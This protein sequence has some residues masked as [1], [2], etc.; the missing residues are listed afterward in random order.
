MSKPTSK[1]K[2]AI[3][4]IFVSLLFAFFSIVLAFSSLFVNMDRLV[5][6]FTTRPLDIV[7]LSI[8]G[9]LLYILGYTMVATGKKGYA[10]FKNFMIVMTVIFFT[11]VICLAV[12]MYFGPYAYPFAIAGLFIETMVRRYIRKLFW[13]YSSCFSTDVLAVLTT[14]YS[15]LYSPAYFRE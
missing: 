11:L 2:T 13:E 9:M 5:E 1:K 10:K 15:S 14:I 7:I 8:I 3:T 4:V 6:V 12:D